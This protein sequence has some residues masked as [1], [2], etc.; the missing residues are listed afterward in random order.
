[1]LDGRVL[2]VVAFALLPGVLASDPRAVKAA[3]ISAEHPRHVPAIKGWRCGWDRSNRPDSFDFLV[4]GT[5]DSERDLQE[6][7]G[8]PDHARGKAAW[9]E[10]ATWRVVDLVEPTAEA[11]P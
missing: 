11:L 4:V 8:H 1:M 10:I 2:H 7:Q 6:F 3:R 5:F 9:S